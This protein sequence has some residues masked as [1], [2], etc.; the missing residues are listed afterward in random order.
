M[1]TKGT[2]KSCFILSAKLTQTYGYFLLLLYLLLS[3]KKKIFNVRFIF[4]YKTNYFKH[5][6][7]KYYQDKL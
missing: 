5:L 3:S 4:V 2:I 1:N 6:H 7:K